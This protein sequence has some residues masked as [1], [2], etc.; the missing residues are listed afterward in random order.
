MLN[1][2][3]ELLRDIPWTGYQGVP[4]RESTKL[5]VTRWHQ[6]PSWPRSRWSRFKSRAKDAWGV[7]TGRLEARDWDD[8][9]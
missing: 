5:P 9:W 2:N 1:E 3:N 8:D 4:I 7:L 6:L